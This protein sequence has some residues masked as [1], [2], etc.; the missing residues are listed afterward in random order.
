MEHE[1]SGALGVIFSRAA[2]QGVPAIW[3]NSGG[4]HGSMEI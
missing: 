4:M 3:A 2:V 1:G